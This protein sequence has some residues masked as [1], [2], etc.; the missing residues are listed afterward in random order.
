MGRLPRN[1]ISPGFTCN[2]IDEAPKTSGFGGFGWG[3]R[4]APVRPRGVHPLRDAGIVPHPAA[5][6]FPA[7]AWDG[8]FGTGPPAS[9]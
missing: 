4:K 6:R 2:Q 7:A 9:L 1:D 5:A 3:R 8:N